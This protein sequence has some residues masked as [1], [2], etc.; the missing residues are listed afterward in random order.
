VR[1]LIRESRTRRE[2]AEIEICADTEF[3]ATVERQSLGTVP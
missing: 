3:A 1:C 2:L